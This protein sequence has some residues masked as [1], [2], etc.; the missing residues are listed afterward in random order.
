MGHGVEI[1]PIAAIF[2]PCRIG[3]ARAAEVIPVAGD[4]LPTHGHA[5]R[6]RGLEPI[7][8]PTKIDHAL[9]HRIRALLEVIPA[10]VIRVPATHKHTQAIRAVP[11]TVIEFPSIRE[12]ARLRKVVTHAVDFNN[13]HSH[14]AGLGIEPIP[15]TPV[16]E[17]A[18]IQ[19]A[20]RV[21]IQ[22]V[23]R[24]VLDPAILG[25]ISHSQGVAFI[26]SLVGI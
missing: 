5:P 24:F 19:I 7:Q 20:L 17:P 23:A 11:G 13:A 8:L 4:E 16:F 21:V 3:A 6:S 25:P 2:K 12:R 26:G 14:N 10:A 1:V 15:R 18:R 9:V 22:P